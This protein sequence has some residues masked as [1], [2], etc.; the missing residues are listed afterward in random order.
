VFRPSLTFSVP[1]A[2]S[3]QLCLSNYLTNGYQT[4]LILIPSTTHWWIWY[5]NSAYTC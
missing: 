5:L 4:E 2:V 3:M 1:A